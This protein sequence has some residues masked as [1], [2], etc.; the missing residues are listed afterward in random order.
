M[1]PLTD[2]QQL[3]A[4]LRPVL[5]A[6]TLVFCT[7][8]PSRLHLLA[9]LDPFATVQETEGLSVVTRQHRALELDVE[10][11]VPFRCI[12]LEVLSSLEAVGLTAAVAT[13]LADIDVAANVIAGAHH[14]HLLVPAEDAERAM[15]A[16]EALSLGG[17]GG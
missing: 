7:L 1:Q 5:R 12:T 14:D 3:I 16:L 11:S 4:H 10:A 9:D 13:A 17:H 8:R 6:E 2:L 15:A